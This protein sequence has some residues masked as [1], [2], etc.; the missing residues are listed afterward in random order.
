MVHLCHNRD[1]PS[2]FKKRGMNFRLIELIDVLN[3]HIST[4]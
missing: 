3:I 1:I 4:K 2:F